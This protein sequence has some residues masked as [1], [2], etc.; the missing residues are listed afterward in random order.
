[1]RELFVTDEI[2]FKLQ[3]LGFNEECVC[4]YNSFNQLKG[5]IISTMDGDYVKTDKRDDRI[6]APLWQQAIDF[7]REEKGFI[8][9]LSYARTPKCWGFFIYGVGY[10]LN[11]LSGEG[12]SY[13]EAR[14]QAVLKAIDVCKNKIS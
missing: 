5:V 11:S 14:E 2:V 13:E 12:W 10:F 4:K 6:P 9:E 7:L 8:I 3:E 1:M